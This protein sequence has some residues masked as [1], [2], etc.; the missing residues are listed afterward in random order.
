MG[1]PT[2]GRSLPTMREVQ[3]EMASYLTQDLAHVARQ[4]GPCHSCHAHMYSQLSRL[5]FRPAARPDPDR[6]G[7]RGEPRQPARTVEAGRP[8]AAQIRRHPQLVAQPSS[9]DQIADTGSARRPGT[10][11]H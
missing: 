1:I 2:V 4:D 6:L 11:V 7:M 10:H 3:V 9:A 8:A 5:L